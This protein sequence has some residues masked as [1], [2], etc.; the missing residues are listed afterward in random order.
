MVITD[1]LGR[2]NLRQDGFQDVDHMER[3]AQPLTK[4]YWVAETTEKIP[5]ITRRAFKFA[6][7][8]PCGPVF[9]VFPENTL[10]EQAKATIMDQSKFTVPMKIRPDPTLV[11]QAAR[12]LLEAHNPLVYIGDE[13]TQSGGQKEVVELTELLGLPVSRHS[14]SIGWSKPFPTRHPLYVGGYLAE[15]RYPGIPDVLLNLGSPMPYVGSHLEMNL[16]TKLIEM[17]LNTTS[18]ARVYPTEVAVGADLKLGIADLIAALRSMAT[19]ARLKKIRELRAAKTQE[20]TAKM[21]DYRLKIARG[22][23]NGPEI[24][25]ERLGLELEEAL[26]KETALVMKVDSGRK[27]EAYMSFGGSEKQYFGTTGEALGWGVPASFGVKLGKPDVPVVA[28]VG[29]GAFLFSGPQPLWSL[30]RYSV[31]VTVVVM[32][33]RSYDNARNRIWASDGKQFETGRDMACYLGDPDVDFAKAASAFGV[34][35]EIV[36]ELSALRPAIQPAKRANVDGRPYLLDVHVERDGI[37]ASSTW[38]PQ[39]SVAAL[40]KRKV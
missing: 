10:R 16:R 24:T 23:A 5:E 40:R 30:A 1:Y 22:P 20:Y 27:M 26:D 14:W 37:G 29:D 12:L 7:T 34:E 3:M 18:L 35:G 17:R 32:N 6:S 4:W 28:V 8:P 11:E 21:L 19:K 2:E 39:F 9:V 15:M 13:I 25:V 36:G 33:N 38:H 31:P